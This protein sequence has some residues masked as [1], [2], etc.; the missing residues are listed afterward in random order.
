M[1]QYSAR[2]NA[3]DHKCSTACTSKQGLLTIDAEVMIDLLGVCARIV[4]HR[5]RVA[6]NRISVKCCHESISPVTRLVEAVLSLIEMNNM[7]L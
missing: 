5:H 6:E 1:P 2:D 4:D 7:I 3:G